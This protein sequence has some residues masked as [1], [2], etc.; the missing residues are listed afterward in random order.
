MLLGEVKHRR[1]TAGIDQLE[2]LRHVHHLLKQRG[3]AG[4]ELVYVLVSTAGFSAELR[5]AQATSRVVLATATELYDDP[6]AG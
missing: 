1:E 3:V 6:P 2:R 4:D 5:A